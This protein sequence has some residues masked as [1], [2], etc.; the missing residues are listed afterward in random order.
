MGGSQDERD[1]RRLLKAIGRQLRK[2]S[3]GLISPKADRVQPALGKLFHR[4]Y[5]AL[6]PAQELLRSAES[7]QALKSIVI[8]HGMTETAREIAARL[9]PEALQQRFAE[10]GAELISQTQAD[11]KTLAKEFP[12]DKVTAITAN[13]YQ[14]ERLLDV[15]NFDFY[16]LLKKLDS[17]FPEQDY[18][19]Q[20]HFL[21][22]PAADVSEDLQDFLE[23]LMHLDTEA[24]WEDVLDILKAY[25]GGSD[26]IQR[27]A[28]H[29]TLAMLTKIK[30]N[31]TLLMMVQLLENNPFYKPGVTN[32]ERRSA[33]QDYVGRIKTQAELTLTRLTREKRGQQV[34]KLIAA[35]FEKALVPTL[36][37]YT[38]KNNLLFS[39]RQIT[40][41][42]HVAQL[43]YLRAFV[44]GFVTHEVED[45]VDLLLVT[46]KWSD[47]NNSRT[48]SD[49]YQTL[50]VLLEEI[51]EFDESIGDDGA[52][53]SQLRTILVKCDRAKKYDQARRAIAKIND[54]AKNL[55]SE[56]MT[57]LLVIA[58]EFKLV[59]EDAARPGGQRL[60]NWPEIRSQLAAADSPQPDA[61]RHLTAVYKR[62]SAM[63]RLLEL[64]PTTGG[65]RAAVASAATAP[66]DETG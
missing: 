13:A 14:L 12:T 52:R 61:N 54:V 4:L 18:V 46:G 20:P 31:R 23:L 45:L 44:L 29:R 11:L 38:E 30:R 26:V 21:P 15:I 19:Y 22:T 34:E 28:F 10:S 56:G 2:S 33:V 48:L 66:A 49:A 65:G 57:R 7:S 43:T 39:K 35:V 1:R 63:Y 6:G 51:A 62:L 64:M 41:Y 3:S 36:E 32:P 60:V 53:G 16:F 40:G 59:V 58:R 24:N 17:R 42:T 27:S 9:S 25:K 50:A 55:V 37:H 47:N 8:E 5:T